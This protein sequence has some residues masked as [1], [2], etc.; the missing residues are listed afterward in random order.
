MVSAVA[1]T[2]T[3]GEGHVESGKLGTGG[4]PMSDV[5]LAPAAPGQ[6]T[7]ASVRFNRIFAIG[8]NPRESRR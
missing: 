1:G 2:D 7:G 3:T 8:I 4:R 6:V 5:S